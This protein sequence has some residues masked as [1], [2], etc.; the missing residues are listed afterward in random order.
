MKNNHVKV[1]VDGQQ[2]D[3]STGFW[4][5]WPFFGPWFLRVVDLAQEQGVKITEI[6]TWRS[7]Y[8]DAKEPAQALSDAQGKSYEC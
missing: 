4:A 3:P 6:P 7:R 8:F 2:Q 5:R 1:C